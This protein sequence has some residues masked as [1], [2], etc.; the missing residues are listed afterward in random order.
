MGEKP[1]RKL[2]T[3]HSLCIFIPKHIKPKFGCFVFLK[4]TKAFSSCSLF[5]QPKSIKALT[6]FLADATL[7]A[8]FTEAK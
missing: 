7:G 5:L 4:V 1:D 3:L 2:H 8:T 6:V